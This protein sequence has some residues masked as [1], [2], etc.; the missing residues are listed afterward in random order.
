[1]NKRN[2]KYSKTGSREISKVIKQVQSLD[3]FQ[4]S[5]RKKGIKVIDQNMQRLGRTDTDLLHLKGRLLEVLEK[6]HEAVTV[7]REILRLIPNH[8]GATMDLGDVYYDLGE[9]RKALIY[10][11]R[12]LKLITTGTGYIGRFKSLLK[13]GD[14]IQAVGGKVEALLAL[15]RPKEAL[16]CTVNALQLYPQDIGLRLDL[17]DAQKQFHDMKSPTIKHSKIKKKRNAKGT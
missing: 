1:M 11:N 16:T 6:F 4:T 7:Y 3:L 14:F 15:K 13:G 10:H 9:Y 5:G 8:L 17:E 12:A 2:Y